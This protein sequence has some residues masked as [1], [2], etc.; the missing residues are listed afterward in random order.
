MKERI[1]RRK[2]LLGG[3]STAGILCG[4]LPRRLLAGPPDRPAGPPDRSAQ[5][6]S[7]PV[8]IERCPSYRPEL[9]RQQLEVALSQ[10][11]DVAQ[12]VRGKTVTVKLNLTG[13]IEKL[14]GRAACETYHVHPHVVAALC[15]IFSDA[16][17]QRI[18][19]AECFYY[20][21]PFEEVLRKAGWD[22]AAIQSAGGQRVR[23]E[24]TR[25]RGPWP[26]YSRVKVPWGGYLFPAFELNQRYEK[27]DVFVSL[28]KLK[29]HASAGVTL[30]AK[31]LFGILPCAL[32]GDDAPSEAS[33]SAR[34]GILHTASKRVPAGVPGDL[35]LP[36]SR[37]KEPWQTRVPRVVADV[38]GARP[39][40][41][42]VIDGIYTM[43][44]GE[45]PWNSGLAAVE[46]KLLMAGR[47]AVC[48][49]AVATAVMG[50][51]PQ[52]AHG[53]FP[54]PGDNHLRLLAAAGVGTI[55]PARIEVR[56]LSIRD[57]RFPFRRRPAVSQDW[58][59][60]HVPCYG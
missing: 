36:P 34:M 20:R 38:V 16:G 3:L 29:D 18:V 37:Y 23:F 45:G 48:T 47:N 41:L 28:A 5:A 14:M 55:D 52:A 19:L 60:R 56:G 17:A 21:E 43:S 12:L 11:G 9:V 42:A 7:A 35:K 13:N 54:F 1:S 33:I 50:Y 44:G 40:D 15:A 2:V 39:I 57:A 32:Y 22:V 24:N 25:H 46:P 31:N 49:D 30:A 58:P 10:C 26:G 59:P 51:D 53:A 6:P 8:A 27:T 4:G